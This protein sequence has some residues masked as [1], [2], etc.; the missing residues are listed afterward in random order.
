AATNFE[1]LVSPRAGP[2]GSMGGFGYLRELLACGGAIHVG[3]NDDG[4]MA[5]CAEPFAELARGCRFAGALQAYDEPNWRRARGELHA[6][7]FAEEFGQFVA[8]DF[9]NLLV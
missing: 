9:D 7:F 8:N 1:R 3:G 6:D 5:I 2:H 4:T